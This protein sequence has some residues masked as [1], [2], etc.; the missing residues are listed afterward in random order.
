HAVKAKRYTYDS[1]GTPTILGP[2]P[3]GWMDTAD[4][5]PIA[6]SAY[7]NPFLFTG[8]EYDCESGLIYSRTRYLDPL[9][10]QRLMP[11]LTQFADNQHV[12]T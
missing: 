12:N 6:C 10:S 1:F 3:D 4:D 9:L 5:T 2:G 7:G 11:T 8:R